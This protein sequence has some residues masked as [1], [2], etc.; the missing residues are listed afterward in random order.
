MNAI[1]RNKQIISVLCDYSG[2]H[3]HNVV[4][5]A[6]CIVGGGRFNKS[7]MCKSLESPEN[8]HLG[9]YMALQFGLD[10]LVSV[11]PYY[12]SSGIKPSYAILYSDVD[13]IKNSIYKGKI[14]NTHAR[15]MSEEI[16]RSIENTMTQF[17][18]I[19]I[20]V[21]YLGRKIGLY[22]YFKLTHQNARQEVRGF[23]RRPT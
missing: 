15:R 23:L 9:E 10:T 14:K 4:G 22:N 2:N 19:Q 3:E 16:F 11:L 1:R 5:L 13:H 20:K 12:E 6:T 18:W 7:S 21:K 17:P 8:V